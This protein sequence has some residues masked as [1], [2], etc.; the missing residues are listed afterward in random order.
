MGRERWSYLLSKPTRSHFKKASKTECMH[1][2]LSLSYSKNCVVK[3]NEARGKTVH[4]VF[5]YLSRSR[6]LKDMGGA[7]GVLL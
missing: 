2:F 4:V 6:L 1:K 3:M 7:Y 5:K